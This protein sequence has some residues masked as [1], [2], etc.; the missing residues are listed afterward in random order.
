V[1][2]KLQE[3]DVLCIHWVDQDPTSLYWLAQTCG[4]ERG[5]AKMPMCSLLSMRMF[6]SHSSC[7]FL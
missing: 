4:W 1:R 3:L 6:F 7:L 2:E 5:Q